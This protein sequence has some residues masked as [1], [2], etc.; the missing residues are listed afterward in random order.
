VPISGIVIFAIIAIIS[1]FYHSVK[2]GAHSRRR[3]HQ[4]SRLVKPIDYGEGGCWWYLS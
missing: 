3:K 4:K 1:L 2:I